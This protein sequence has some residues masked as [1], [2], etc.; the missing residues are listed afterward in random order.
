[1]YVNKKTGLKQLWS[2][3]QEKYGG[4]RR[5]TV[6]CKAKVTVMER[7]EKCRVKCQ[8]RENRKKNCTRGIRTPNYRVKRATTEKQHVKTVSRA[9]AIRLYLVN[10]YVF[11]VGLQRAARTHTNPP[12]AVSQ[13]LDK[14]PA[15]DVYVYIFIMC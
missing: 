4:G 3:N 14:T 9:A 12:S 2:G 6:R 1:M 15:A 10:G 5:S 8:D 7:I 13:S 11:H